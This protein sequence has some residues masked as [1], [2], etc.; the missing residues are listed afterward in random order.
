MLHVL[1][2]SPF[3]IDTNSFF[4]LIKNK[5]D[6][7]AIQDGVII[8]LNNNIFLNKIILLSRNLYV[9]EE[10][11]EARGILKNVSKNFSKINYFD[12]IDLTKKNK[13]QIRW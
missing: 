7:I 8:S 11:L 5:D 12:F 1:T 13:C 9:L 4:G 3:C 10:D 6:F 2:S